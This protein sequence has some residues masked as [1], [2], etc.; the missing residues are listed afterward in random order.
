M[1]C[2]IEGCSGIVFLTGLCKKHKTQEY[3]NKRKEQHK[4]Y[5]KNNKEKRQKYLENRKNNKTEQQI[6]MEREYHHQYYLN[7]IDKKKEYEKQYRKDGRKK[8][9]IRKRNSEWFRLYNYKRIRKDICYKLGRNLR[10]RLYCAI[11]QNRRGS[12][13]CDLGCSINKL[14]IHLQMKFIRHPTDGHYMS[15]DNYGKFG[16]HIDHIIPLSAFDLTN[17]EELKKACHYT[18]LQPLWW[19]DNVRKSNKIK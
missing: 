8:R 16:W 5:R 9:G 17:P 11:K 7:N 13:V 4:E 19:K 3:N 14:K 2:R 1:C 6:E 12:A 18:N 10:S 15:W